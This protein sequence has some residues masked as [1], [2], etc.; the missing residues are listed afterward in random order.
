MVPQDCT[1]R[2]ISRT[3]QITIQVAVKDTETARRTIVGRTSGALHAEQSFPKGV[4]PFRQYVEGH[5]DGIVP[6]CMCH[7]ARLRK[8]LSH[9]ASAEQISRIGR[10][11]K[12]KPIQPCRSSLSPQS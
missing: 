10:G 5:S 3:G 8:G 4:F 11:L 9:K 12:I 7:I 2:L 1:K 6:V